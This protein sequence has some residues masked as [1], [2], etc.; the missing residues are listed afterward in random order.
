MNK[1]EI[2]S[3]TNSSSSKFLSESNRNSSNKDFNA[4]ND[5]IEL[6]EQFEYCGEDDKYIKNAKENKNFIKD[7]LLFADQD[8]NG[9]SKTCICSTKLI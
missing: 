9:I 5:P 6:F 7:Y 3:K 1:K 8:K 2:N 4:K